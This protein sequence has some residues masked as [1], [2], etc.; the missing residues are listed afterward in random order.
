[1]SPPSPA[2]TSLVC[3]S[4]NPA[5]YIGGFNGSWEAAPSGINQSKKRALL[6]EE[7]V[8]FDERGW[9]LDRGKLWDNFKV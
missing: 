6:K 1:M 8:L 4:N 7:G 9:L 2:P 3:C 5:Q